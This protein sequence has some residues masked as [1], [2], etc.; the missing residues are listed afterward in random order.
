[1]GFPAICARAEG[2]PSATCQDWRVPSSAPERIFA[3]SELKAR[4]T[5]AQKAKEKKELKVRKDQET[6]SIPHHLSKKI[7][8]SSLL[9]Y[10]LQN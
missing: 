1:M 2:L 10:K 9:I 5:K 4:E 6:I 3:L 8:T 7:V